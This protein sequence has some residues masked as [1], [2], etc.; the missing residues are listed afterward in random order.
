[1]PTISEQLMQQ[2]N[3]DEL[4]QVGRQIGTDEKTTDSVLSMAMPLLVSALANNASQP[5]GAES[6]HQALANDHDGSI[7]NDIPSFLNNPQAANGAGI[8]GHVLGSQ[9]SAVTQG[10]AQNSGLNGDQIGQILQIAAPLLMGFLG[11]EQQSQ[12]L[13]TNDLASLLSGQQQTAQQENPDMMNMLN[14]LLDFD[15]D[16]S[17]LDDIWGM[18]SG[19][20]GKK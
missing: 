18:L 14:Q 4:S 11:K 3:E 15:K 6:L 8:L 7:L 2:L 20:F 9:Q 12:G 17:A 10:L 1:M 19:L 16:G 13:N 5:E